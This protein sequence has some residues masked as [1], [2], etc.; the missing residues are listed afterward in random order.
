MPIHTSIRAYIQSG[1]DVRDD[2]RVL[3]LVLVMLIR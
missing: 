1:S 2:V 3:M